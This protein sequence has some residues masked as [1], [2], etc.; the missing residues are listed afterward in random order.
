M[1]SRR[2]LVLFL[3]LVLAFGL[4]LAALGQPSQNCNGDEKHDNHPFPSETC[5]IQTNPHY[6]QATVCNID[7]GARTCGGCYDCCDGM[8]REQV[9]CMCGDGIGSRAC[10]IAAGNAN[11]T[12]R[13]ACPDAFADC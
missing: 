11:Q 13:H 8:Q 5:V 4:A 6:W 1:S 7:G 3:G 10:T 2:D 12:C 9:D